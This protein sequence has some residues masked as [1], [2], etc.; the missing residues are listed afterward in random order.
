MKHLFFVLALVTTNLVASIDAPP[1]FSRTEAYNTVAEFLN[2]KEEGKRLFPGT[3]ETGMVCYLIVETTATSLTLQYLN[4]FS[5]IFTIP[6]NGSVDV[7]GRVDGD[8]L[9]AK[10]F[11]DKPGSRIP[12]QFSTEYAMILSRNPNGSLKEWAFKVTEHRD[13]NFKVTHARICKF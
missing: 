11:I 10:Y 8:Q 4:P 12:Q 6:K 1:F 9:S 3:D 7:Y 2:I 5:P 13:L